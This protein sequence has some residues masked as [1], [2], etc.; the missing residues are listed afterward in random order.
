[1]TVRFSAMDFDVFTIAGFTE[2]MDAIRR[3]IRPKLATV[4]E[5]L[6]PWLEHETGLEFY[7]HVATHARRRVNPPD[8]TWVAFSRS[9]RGYKRYIH[10]AVAIDRMGLKTELVVKPEL[11]DRSVF[12]ERLARLGIQGMARLLG[13]D[14]TPVYWY[15]GREGGLPVSAMSEADFQQ[16]L[17]SLQSKKSAGAALSCRLP[18]EEVLDWE[19][20]LMINTLRQHLIRLVPLY[21]LPF[22]M[23][24]ST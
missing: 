10:L 4:G 1:M 9:A 15:D 16:I 3:Q 24:S 21:V 19:P 7:Y 6:T 20:P 17:E 13:K 23:P 5:Q 18:K 14:G 22:E 2:R 12:A 11:D 8:D